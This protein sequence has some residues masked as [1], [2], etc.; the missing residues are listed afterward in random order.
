VALGLG[1]SVGFRTSESLNEGLFINPSVGLS[2]KLSD[3]SSVNAGLSYEIQHMEFS[4]LFPDDIP[5]EK[6]PGSISFSI[7]ISF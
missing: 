7:G 4:N 6:Y 5:Y 3:K 1:S 2:F